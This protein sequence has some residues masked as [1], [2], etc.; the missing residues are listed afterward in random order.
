MAMAMNPQ[1]EPE[2]KPQDHQCQFEDEKGVQCRRDAIV[3]YTFGDIR[4]YLCPGHL[5]EV[6]EKRFGAF[7]RPLGF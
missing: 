5:V 4:I 1:T 2:D 3:L 6:S 7:F